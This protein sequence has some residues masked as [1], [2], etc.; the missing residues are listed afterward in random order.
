VTNARGRNIHFIWASGG[1]ASAELVF[2]PDPARVDVRSRGKGPDLR[3]SWPGMLF[4][5][6]LQLVVPRKRV[7]ATGQVFPP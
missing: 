1:S 7:L 6:R 5:N 3:S 2:N 4:A